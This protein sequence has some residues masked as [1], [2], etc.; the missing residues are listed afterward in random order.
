MYTW[1]YIYMCNV[2]TCMLV[3]GDTIDTIDIQRATIGSIAY[4]TEH[5]LY[6]Y[7]VYVVKAKWLP[8][9]IERKYNLSP[10][11]GATSEVW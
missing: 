1:K 2:T 6:V 9:R 7:T 8:A 4:N 5:V 11:P 10:L 3:L